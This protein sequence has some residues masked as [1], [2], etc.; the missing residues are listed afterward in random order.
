M[1]GEKI[2]H[3]HFAKNYSIFCSALRPESYNN[4]II[5]FTGLMDENR[6]SNSGGAYQR[7]LSRLEDNV[8]GE[9]RDLLQVIA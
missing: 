7:L 1:E 9:E 3:R 4:D 8:G 2:D 5:I 6:R